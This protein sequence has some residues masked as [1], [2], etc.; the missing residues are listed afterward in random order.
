M[1]QHTFAIIHHLVEDIL[2][3]SDDELIDA[4]YFLAER[5]KTIVEPTACLGFAAAK[6]IRE[7]LKGQRIGII[8]SGGN[9]DMKRYAHLLANKN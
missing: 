1:G 7:Q 9:I 4:M 5:M 2:T 3:A 8:L 6:A